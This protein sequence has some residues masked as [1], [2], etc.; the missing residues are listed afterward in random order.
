VIPD[1]PHDL[2][3]TQ[4]TDGLSNPARSSTSIYLKLGQ[5]FGPRYVILQVL[6]EGGMGTVYRAHDKELD[7]EVALKLIKPTVSGRPEA[8]ERFKREI[9]LASKITHK[10][11]LRIHDLG[12]ID[13]IKYISMNYVEGEDLSK[14]IR[15][16]GPLPTE[17]VIEMAKQLCQALQ[18]A[19]DEGVLH[20]DLKPQNVM[21]D[22]QGTVYITDFGLARSVEM[23]GDLSLTATGDV[24]GTPLYM[25]P[26][27]VK[28]Q[29]LDQRSD[30]YSLG[31]ILYEMLTGHCPFVEPSSYATL[32]KRTQERPKDPRE[33]NPS[34]PDYLAR[35]VLKCLDPDPVIR[36]QDATE[37]L[38][39]LETRRVQR[40]VG[41]VLHPAFRRPVL[42]ILAAVL[43][44]ASG[45]WW[46]INRWMQS[47]LDGARSAT[48]VA[49]LPLENAT[50][51]VASDWMSLGI[52]DLVV[53]DLWESE[54]LR[55]VSTERVYEIIE[56][57][58]LLEHKQLGPSSL[59]RMAEFSHAGFV[60]TGKFSKSGP[61]LRLDAA[62]SGM[63][64]QREWPITIENEQNLPNLAAA[65]AKEIRQRLGVSAR[66]TSGPQISRPEEAL[67]FYY[68]GLNFFHQGDNSRA[69]SE[70]QQAVDRDPTFAL[71]YARLVEVHHEQ[72]QRDQVE[73]L[74]QKALSS[75][76]ALPVRDRFY[77]QAILARTVND[78]DKAIQSYQQ[79]L[80]AYPDDPR[81]YFELA[82]VYET[83]GQWDHALENFQKAW[84]LDPKSVYTLT[85]LG[86]IELRRGNPQ[87]AL[88]YLM[89]AQTL[90]AQLQN[91]RERVDLLSALG[92]VYEQLAFYD[93]ALEHYQKAFEISRAVNDQPKMAST[94]NEIGSIYHKKGRYEEARRSFEQALS[95]NRQ[96]GDEGGIG[97]LL[98][99]LGVLAE[100]FA[101]YDEALDYYTQALNS[102]RARKAR[103]ETANR[104]NNIGYVYFLMGRATDA[105]T[106]FQLA[107][108]EIN[109]TPD[110]LTKAMI[111]GPYGDL[112]VEQGEYGR[113]M[114]HHSEA[115]QIWTEAQHTEGVAYTLLSQGRVFEAQGQYGTALKVRERALGM[116]R[117]LGDKL[118]QAYAFIDVGHSYNLLGE[119]QKADDHFQQAQPLVNEIGND[120]LSARLL[121]RR[122]ERLRLQGQP[123]GAE[124]WLTEARQRADQSKNPSA[125]ILAR[126]ETGAVYNQAQRV[127]R[128]LPLL[129]PAVK[130]AE[131][132]DFKS[133]VVSA[134]IELACVYLL[135]KRSAQAAREIQEATR[136]AER[137][138]RREVLMVCHFLAAKVS[139]A[140]NQSGQ[141][142]VQFQQ[143][144][145]EAQWV[146]EQIGADHAPT[147][148][149]RHDVQELLHQAG[150]A[151]KAA[152]REHEFS[153]FARWLS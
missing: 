68:Q 127:D 60:L 100:E 122:G 63:A 115:L 108:Q 138:G 107:L 6:G 134:K 53:A 28:G 29:P 50:G 139:Q 57:L 43:V 110:R 78:H 15:R 88:K 117:D 7:R 114:A 151:F 116:M 109:Q 26:E 90:N 112:L 136:L 143:A 82:A 19:H 27:Q 17:R 12:D 132:L 152:G 61:R 1:D 71:A 119:F 16:E 35:I 46:L 113:A 101:H 104:L 98:N 33:P 30:L 120:E 36:Y 5:D 126:I 76:D 83:M 75:P 105:A 94:L 92:T 3:I 133:L 31:L 96:I 41:T 8:L 59:R 99:N 125:I 52:A 67:K 58:R 13:G 84:E 146:R 42:V 24:M 65:L 124:R 80:A 111:L 141:A 131:A 69:M 123:A 86:Q 91:D 2:T 87:T 34:I 102:A 4:L 95:T 135:Q 70:W 66:S 22:R 85:K 89:E 81:G 79:L 149:R 23:S 51:D 121:I 153:S 32:F 142:L 9:L 40:S 148:V 55:P 38:N 150:Q 74:A 130:E 77:L 44:I 37:I 47:R 140:Q 20:R 54:D 11:V 129:L 39:D 48:V 45:S 118:G 103:V 145:K 14:I 106:Y 18:A 93:S 97:R 62:L 49:V 64:Q 10:N 21:V 72:G 56:D 25:S 147:F 128:A 73:P 137:L 144:L